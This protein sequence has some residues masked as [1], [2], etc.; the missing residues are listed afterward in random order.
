MPIPVTVFTGFLGSGKTTII[1]NII[2]QLPPDY[3]LVVLKNE[4]GNAQ[5]DSELYK[6]SN[7]A[8]TEMINGCL[9]CVLVGK[10]GNALNEILSKFTPDRIIIETSGS[11]YPGPIAW[12]IR[13]IKELKLDGI[14]NVIDAINFKGYRDTSYTAKLQAKD[15]DLILINKH[16]LVDPIKLDK[17]LDDVYEVNPETPK[18][19][20]AY[21][22]INPNIIFGLDTKLFSTEEK[23]HEED[24][25]NQEHHHLEAE[26]IEVYKDMSFDASTFRKLLDELPSWD[27]FRIKGIVKLNARFYLVNYVLGKYD[28]TPYDS[29]QGKPKLVFIGKNLEFHK[30]QIAKI[31]DIDTKELIAVPQH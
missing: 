28:L 18:V 13:R 24:Q 29:Y 20:T 6:Q 26:V 10:L 14:I 4:Y 17:T 25:H 12:E 23:S 2:K 9:C 30:Q 11:A 8:V 21:G 22:V 1:L 5:I 3:K 27:F 19:K 31:L 7:I 16:E 15:T